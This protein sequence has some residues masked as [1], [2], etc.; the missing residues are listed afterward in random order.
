VPESAERVYSELPTFV[1]P[2]GF[3]NVASAISPSAWLLGLGMAVVLAT[4]ALAGIR[5]AA[6]RLMG[7]GR[8]EAGW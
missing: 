3:E 8:T 1:R 5:N 7:L 6:A 2:C 4:V